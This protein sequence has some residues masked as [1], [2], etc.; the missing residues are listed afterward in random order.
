[1]KTSLKINLFSPPSFQI[2]SI[3][4][5]HTLWSD[6]TLGDDFFLSPFC[7]MLLFS[8]SSI[9]VFLS[10]YLFSLSLYIFISFL[11]LFCLCLFLNLSFF[12]YVSHFSVF[13]SLFFFSFSL[14]SFFL[15][16]SLSFHFSI[17]F[18]IFSLSNL[19]RFYTSC[20]YILLLDFMT[21]RFNKNTICN[22][23]YF[24]S[25]FY[26]ILFKPLNLFLLLEIFHLSH[27]FFYCLLCYSFE[28]P[29][30]IFF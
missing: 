15:F 1:M 19:Q 24:F 22:S 20:A 10:I 25:F 30:P 26:S 8:L 11:P 12:E 27:S 7:M 21:L 5:S 6:E 23:S 16:F 2:R 14:F 17:S 18:T 3:S 13:L 4:I 29:V 28:H 9:S